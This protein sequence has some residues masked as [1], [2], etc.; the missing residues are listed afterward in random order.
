MSISCA[1]AAPTHHPPGEAHAAPRAIPLPTRLAQVAAPSGYL[2]GAAARGFIASSPIEQP[3]SSCRLTTTRHA[4]PQLQPAQ[5][6][7][8]AV[9][10]NASGDT[11][12]HATAG[13][14]GWRTR[15]SGRRSRRR[16]TPRISTEETLSSHD[17]ATIDAPTPN[18]PTTSAYCRQKR[19]R[20][21]ATESRATDST[22]C[23]PVV[24]P[25]TC[26][27]HSNPLPCQSLRFLSP[28]T[29]EATMLPARKFARE[30]TTAAIA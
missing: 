30:A 29:C 21:H 2:G 24:S 9:A 23:R 17:H 8:P 18:H 1:I 12:R 11:R 3:L 10:K 5:Q 25:K 13:S 15:L 20:R 14:P 27:R 6:L 19:I 26:R 16:L 7:R 22:P 28:E 4:T